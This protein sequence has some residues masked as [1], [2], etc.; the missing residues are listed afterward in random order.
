M[1]LTESNVFLN[2]SCVLLENG[3]VFLYDINDGPGINLVHLK[4]IIADSLFRSVYT[5]NDRVYWGYTMS[6]NVINEDGIQSQKVTVLT[7]S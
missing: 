5:L 3:N 1:N 7:E 4:R 2:I 6:P